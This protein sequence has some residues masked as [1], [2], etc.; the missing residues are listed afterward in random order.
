MQTSQRSKTMVQ[1]QKFTSSI[2]SLHARDKSN[3]DEMKWAKKM[4]FSHLIFLVCNT[5]KTKTTKTI[6]WDMKNMIQLENE[7]IFSKGKFWKPSQF[8]LTRNS[9][10]WEFTALY[11]VRMMAMVCLPVDGEWQVCQTFQALGGPKATSVTYSNA[12][13][14]WERTHQRNRFHSC[15]SSLPAQSLLSEQPLLATLSDASQGGQR[16][17]SAL[18]FYHLGNSQEPVMLPVFSKKNNQSILTL[19]ENRKLMRFAKAHMQ[20]QTWLQHSL[21]R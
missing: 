5:H 18:S 21:R 2:P 1:K 13:G 16:F 4:I 12:Y 11:S 14:R 8:A 17:G 15:Q 20:S 7:V 19:K 10:Q 3:M 9:A 6:P